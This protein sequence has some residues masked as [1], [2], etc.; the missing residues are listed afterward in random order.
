MS[1][2]FVEGHDTPRSQ[3]NDRKM[4]DPE[5][6]LGVLPNYW[7]SDES[8]FSLLRKLMVIIKF[9]LAL[10]LHL[11]TYHRRPASHEAE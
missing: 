9:I 6:A 11:M 4:K 3:L 7:V 2:I 1:L 8:M 10:I 5:F